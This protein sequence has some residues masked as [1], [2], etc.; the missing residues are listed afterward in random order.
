[1]LSKM[2]CSWWL[3]NVKKAKM[4]HRFE[5]VMYAIG[6]HVSLYAKT[7][8][9]SHDKYMYYKGTHNLMPY[10]S[11]I[12]QSLCRIFSHC[13]HWETITMWEPC[14]ALMKGLLSV[15]VIKLF[16]WTVWILALIWHTK[17]CSL[18]IPLFAGFF[19]L[20]LR[21]D[22]FRIQI[23]KCLCHHIK[24]QLSVFIRAQT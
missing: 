7:D 13:F 5:G 17:I 9:M 24:H 14:K 21:R 22:F 10:L 1:M 2:V 19:Q 8:L 20:S 6:K 11:R 18:F 23:S 16:W 4:P 15:W 3:R 12:S